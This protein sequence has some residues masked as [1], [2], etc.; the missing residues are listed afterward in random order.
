MNDWFLRHKSNPC[1]LC[2]LAKAFGVAFCKTLCGSP[3]STLQRFNV[4]STQ[5]VTIAARFLIEHS[6]RAVVEG[7]GVV[8]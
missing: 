7:L 2:L 1:F 8:T 3:G 6:D 4:S 5:R